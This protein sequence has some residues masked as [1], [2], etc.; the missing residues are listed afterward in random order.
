MGRPVKKSRFGNTAGDFE[1]TG[2]FATTATQPDGTG[3]EAVS[4]ASVNYI[5]KQRSS[6][7]F[8]INFT[9]ADGSTRLEQTLALTAVAP[10]SLT[11]GQFCVQLILDDSTVAYVA[12]FFNRTVHYVTAAGATGAIAYAMLT[13]ATDEGNTAGKGT[14]D[15]L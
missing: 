9:S 5:V 12:K 10:G 6:K 7:R 8:I 1:V 4:T 3:A 11:A 15:V 2:A 14:I 13:E